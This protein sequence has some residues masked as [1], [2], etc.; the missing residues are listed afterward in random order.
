MLSSPI[1]IKTK[2]MKKKDPGCNKPELSINDQR[3]TL[4]SLQTVCSQFYPKVLI[5]RHY[6]LFWPLSQ[7]CRNTAQKAN[8]TAHGH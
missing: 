7:C 1:R 2:T 6:Q 8:D 5:I 4:I 3:V